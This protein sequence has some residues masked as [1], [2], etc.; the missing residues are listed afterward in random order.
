MN[1]GMMH[2]DDEKDLYPSTMMEVVQQEVQ[3][4]G[5]RRQDQAW[6]LSDRDVWMKNPYY[7]GPAVQHP[8]MGE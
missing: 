8:E 7:R 1:P 3:D 6:I 5:S 4:M 2:P